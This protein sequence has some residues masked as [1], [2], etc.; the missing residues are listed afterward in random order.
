[1]CGAVCKRV[2]VFAPSLQHVSI[3]SHNHIKGL[4]FFRFLPLRGDGRDRRNIE[5]Q[6]KN[7]AAWEK[8]REEIENKV[9]G[10]ASQQ[11]FAPPK[12][13]ISHFR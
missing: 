9:E 5:K 4:S 7:F 6:R 12:I 10:K 8:K 11:N 1:M 3:F 13:Q 2:D